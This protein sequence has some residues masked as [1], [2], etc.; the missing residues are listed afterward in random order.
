MFLHLFLTVL[1]KLLML[2]QYAS[3][4]LAKKFTVVALEN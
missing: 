1:M 2:T 3:I 4:G